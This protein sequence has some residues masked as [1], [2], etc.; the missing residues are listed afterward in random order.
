MPSA[1]LPP[2]G[3]AGLRGFS[4]QRCG[5]HD[6]SHGLGAHLRS[7][8]SQDAREETR[9]SPRALRPLNLGRGVVALAS[10][11]ISVSVKNCVSG[12]APA[13]QRASFLSAP[14]LPRSSAPHH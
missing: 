8:R 10:T 11:S 3:A 5:A 12:E 13:A 9:P 2:A 4:A 1:A 6:G 7:R 14:E